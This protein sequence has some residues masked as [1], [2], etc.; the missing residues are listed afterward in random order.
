MIKCLRDDIGHEITDEAQ[1]GQ[2]ATDFF[3]RM[4][5]KFG[6]GSEAL[7]DRH[8]SKLPTAIGEEDNCQLLSPISSEEVQLAV[9]VMGAYKTLGLDGFP[10]A[11][12]LKYWDIVSFDVTR[13]MKDFFRTGKLLKKMNNT[14]IVLVPKSQDP[15]CMMAF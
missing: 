9:F 5:T 8:L 10:P 4:Y 7:Q 12:F 13:A 2:F 15:R 3:I 14:F 6:G 1:I 11:F